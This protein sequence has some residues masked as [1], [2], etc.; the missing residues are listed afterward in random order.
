MKWLAQSNREISDSSDNE[1]GRPGSLVQDRH[2]WN[3]VSPLP[4]ELHGSGTA[5]RRN[6][7]NKNKAAILESGKACLL[8]GTQARIKRRKRQCLKAAKSIVYWQ[9][10]CPLLRTPPILHLTDSTKIEN[11]HQNSDWFPKERTNRRKLKSCFRTR[12]Q[13]IRMTEDW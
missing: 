4:K 6:T 5:E 9:E 13:E 3:R 7:R 2:E 1:P 12:N 11:T 8:A 10:V